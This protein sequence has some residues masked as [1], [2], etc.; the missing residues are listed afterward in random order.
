M[1]QI[2]RKASNARIQPP[3]SICAMAKFSMKTKLHPVGCNELFDRPLPERTARPMLFAFSLMQSCGLIS[4]QRPN[5]RINP[6]RRAAFNLHRR[7]QHEKH[8]IEA[9]G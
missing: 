7:K 2:Q 8:A 6:R 4:A 9:S 3:A 5:A 1:F